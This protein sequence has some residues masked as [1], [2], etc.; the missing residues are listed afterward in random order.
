MIISSLTGI[1]DC[2]SEGQKKKEKKVR[3]HT[4]NPFFLFAD[5]N[6][7]ENVKLK[8]INERIM[9]IKTLTLL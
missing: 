5:M 4:K 6:E 9:D 7:L 2:S 1:P 8:Y 3:K